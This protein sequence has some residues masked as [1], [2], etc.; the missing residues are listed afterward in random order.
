MQQT[1]INLIKFPWRWRW[2]GGRTIRVYLNESRKSNSGLAFRQQRA[3][4]S[5][6]CGAGE[7]Y[8]SLNWWL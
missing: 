8:G 1:F 6:G 4:A 5:H 2:W 7:Q 3:T